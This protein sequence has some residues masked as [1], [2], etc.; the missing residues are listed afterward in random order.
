MRKSRKEIFNVKTNQNCQIKFIHSRLNIR[1][2]IRIKCFVDHKIRFIL[3]LLLLKR[4]S[5]L[6]NSPFAND[7]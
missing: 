2:N 3:I 5:F 7:F 4:V 6:L 1:R